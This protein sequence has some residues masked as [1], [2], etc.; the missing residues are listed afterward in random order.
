V[1][2]KG[3]TLEEIKESKTTDNK[4]HE[5]EDNMSET[6]I[7]S[8]QKNV[9]EDVYDPQA[10]HLANN[11]RDIMSK[12]PNHKNKSRKSRV[13]PEPMFNPRMMK[14][15]NKS[16]KQQSNSYSDHSHIIKPDEIFKSLSSSEREDSRLIT[17]TKQIRSKSFT[18]SDGIE[19]DK[20]NHSQAQDDQN[21][22]IEFYKRKATQSK[23]ESARVDFNSKIMTSFPATGST[24]AKKSTVSVNK[25]TFEFLNSNRRSQESYE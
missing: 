8:K 7:N 1:L 16:L 13:A 15:Q 25:L 6:N 5:T 24:Y 12:D 23:N 2:L 9:F 20:E 21:T 18:V 22:I 4:E 10:N 19:D 11:I 17:N 3:S 14:K